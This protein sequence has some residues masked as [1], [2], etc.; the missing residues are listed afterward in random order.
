MMSRQ[1]RIQNIL[2]DTL[3]PTTL[4]VENESPSHH[5]PFGIP[6]EEAETHFKV[7]AVADCFKTL[8]RVAR[9]RLVNRAMA[10]ELATGLHALS[11]HLYTPEEW[12][13]REQNAPDSPPCRGGSRH[14]EKG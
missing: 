11:L 9:H 4:L 12:S 13:L 2:T 14:D 3:K 5:T 7:I 8:N 10:E 6:K 1:Q